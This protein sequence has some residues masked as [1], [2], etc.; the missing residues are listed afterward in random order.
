MSDRAI[1][2][3][4]PAVVGLA[5]CVA[6]SGCGSSRRPDAGDGGVADAGPR[7][8]DA[9]SL[10]GGRDAGPPPLPPLAFDVDLRFTH[11]FPAALVPERAAGTLTLVD[12][13]SDAPRVVLSWDGEVSGARLTT[14]AGHERALAA[15][16]TVYLALTRSRGCAAALVANFESLRFTIVDDDGDGDPDRV[17]GDGAGFTPVIQGDLG[18][19]VRFEATFEGERDRAAPELSLQGFTTRAHP[20]DVPV[21][22]AT[23]ALA[24][25]VTL[26]LRTRAGD[27]VPLP[28]GR[29]LGEAALAEGHAGFA[30]ASGW[31]LAFG[32]TYSL[33]VAPA[34]RDLV[35]LEG[36]APDGARVETLRHPGRVTGT[37]DLESDVAMPPPGLL[38]TGEG[39]GVVVG[40]GPYTPPEGNGAI[41][42]RPDGRA[43]VVLA[44]R[45]PAE[46]IRFDY[47]VLSR[48]PGGFFLASVLVRRPGGD[49][50]A[51]DVDL[52]PPGAFTETGDDAWPWES[53]VQTAT[54][55]IEGG[56]P[57]GEELA[58]DV[59]APPSTRCGLAPQATPFLIDAIRLE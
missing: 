53:D 34:L 6:L 12:R 18:F 22:R 5:A 38:V 33:D 58:L 28:P 8:D 30:P 44:A 55:T 48:S 24:P 52:P 21:V 32:T 3:P 49:A 11:D 14:P 1:R 2:R 26:A 43:T 19:T 13:G 35:G 50:P 29:P 36:A 7:L 39:S 23:E 4:L 25:D 47:R 31:S 42:L 56:V 37:L 45:E 10:D 17:R 54:V 51:V 40:A 9:G 41:L 46:R 57:A 20:L 27:R 15:G 16:Q 59:R